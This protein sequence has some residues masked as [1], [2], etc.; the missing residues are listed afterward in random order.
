MRKLVPD[1][2]ID[3][4]YN[5]FAQI[6]SDA[7]QR[8]ANMLVMKDVTLSKAKVATSTR[9]VTKIQ[10]F[11]RD[12]ILFSYCTHPRVTD[13]AAN[14]VGNNLMSVH[15][16]LINKPPDTG[17]GSSRHPLH[18]D[19]WYF[20]F[21]PADRI[22]ASWTAMQRVDVTNGCLW[23]IPGSHRSELMQHGYPKWEA[24]NKA[25]HGVL[26]LGDHIDC[27][28]HPSAIPVIMEKGD[29]VF[30]HPLL[31]H[32]SGK[33]NSDGMRASISAHFAASECYWIDVE[34]TLQTEVKNE[35]R[36]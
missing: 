2:D 21:R 6:C 33:N 26:K 14:I 8:T 29:T 28:S 23:V 36:H 20:P 30:F 10:N 1:D 4:F 7:S 31:L 11:E 22:V 12:P 13:V 18:Q 16:M 3:T 32:G 27:A 17:K 5:R 15:T 19:L 24:A 9:T 35:V 34:G 25:Y